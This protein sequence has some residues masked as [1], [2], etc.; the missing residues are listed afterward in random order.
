M[1]VTAGV[2]ILGLGLAIACGLIF[3]TLLKDRHFVYTPSSFG[4]FASYISSM[5][6]SLITSKK[7][8]LLLLNL[9]TFF[10]RVERIFW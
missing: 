2:T 3:T 4:K 8:W 7:K 5:L 10:L 1:T 9:L 6:L